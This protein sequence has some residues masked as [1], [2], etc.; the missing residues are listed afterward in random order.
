[1]LSFCDVIF[2]AA[3]GLIMLAVFVLQ[4]TI[5]EAQLIQATLLVRFSLI[6]LLLIPFFRFFASLKSSQSMGAKRLLSIHWFKGIALA[7]FDMN[8]IF[9][10]NFD[11]L[12]FQFIKVTGAAEFLLINSLVQKLNL[13]HQSFSAPIF[14]NNFRTKELLVL[15]CRMFF[16]TCFVF[17]SMILLFFPLVNELLFLG[18]IKESFHLAVVGILLL[19]LYHHKASCSACLCKK[20]GCKTK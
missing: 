16:A 17:A 2:N 3:Q 14:A 1:M 13:V 5:S 11:K 9:S 15:T 19:F 20:E 7:L 12:L 10:D 8:A 4:L 18:K 6:L